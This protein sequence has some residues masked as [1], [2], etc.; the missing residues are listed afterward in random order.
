MNDQM[1]D[2]EDRAVLAHLPFDEV[3]PPPGLEDRVMKAALARRPTTP[4]RS[5]RGQA[6][7]AGLAVAALIAAVVMIAVNHSPARAPTRIETTSATKADVEQMLRAPGVRTGA[8]SNRAGRVALAPNGRGYLFDLAATGKVAVAIDNIGL[9]HARPQAGIIEIKVQHPNLVRV[10]TVTDA[11]GQ[12]QH[13][14][15]QP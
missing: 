6:I 5:R 11:S 12:V 3:A 8:F 2:D 1:W 4:T 9:G 7:L 13:A 10:V 15:L 14:T